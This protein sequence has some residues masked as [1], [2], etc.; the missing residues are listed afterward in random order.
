MQ[1]PAAIQPSPTSSSF[2]GLLAA[3]AT[4][5]SAASAGHGD[6]DHV[7]AWNDDDLADDVATLSYERALRAH[8]RYKSPN[9][10]YRKPAAMPKPT[11]MPEPGPRPAS[12][13]PALSP[14]ASSSAPALSPRSAPPSCADA[15]S[16]IPHSPAP[17]PDRKLKCASITIR[18]SRAEC[19]LLRERAAEAGL[20]V[21]AYLRSCTF[22]V[23]SLR[24]QV[25]EA[26][27]QFRAA[28]S[29]GKPAAPKLARPSWVRRLLSR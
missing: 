15:V 2:A 14:H 9:P 27:A 4:Q 12:S 17:A 20:T 6:A 10:V 18:L 23:E 25:K 22:E 28:P 5:A 13:H 19:D 1:Q 26:L 29:S 11:A 7:P 21:S 16:A 24:A 8:T 3:L